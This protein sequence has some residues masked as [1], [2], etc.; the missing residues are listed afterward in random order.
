MTAAS[1]SAS[2]NSFRP[3]VGMK[4]PSKKSLSPSTSMKF[5]ETDITNSGRSRCLSE[6]TVIKTVAGDGGNAR[7]EVGRLATSTLLGRPGSVVVDAS[8]NLYIADS[9]NSRILMVTKSTGIVTAVAGNGTFDYSG[10]GG[11]ATAAQLGNPTGV[12]VDAS[13]NLYFADTSSNRIR[14]VTK[15]TGIINTVAGNGSSDGYSGDGGLATSATVPYPTGVAVDAS[16]NIYITVK[17]A[18]ILMVTKSTGII[19]TVAG[20]GTAG[21]EGDGGLA[22]SATMRYPTGITVDA[23]GNIYFADSDN[24]CIRMVTKS[25]GIITTVAGVRTSAIYEYFSGDGGP[26]TSAT[27]RS[28][29][30]VAVDASGN[31]Y[32]SDSGNNRI[33]MVTKSTGIITTVAGKGTAGYGGDGRLATSAKLYSPDGITVD[34]SGNIYFADSDNNR[35]RMVTKSTGVISVAAGDG[36]VGYAGNAVQATSARLYSPR[37]VT[38]DASGNIYITDWYSN[39]I[40]MMEKTTG[41]IT[42]VAGNTSFYGVNGV[43]GY[44][45]DG[46]PAT[47]ATLYHPRD[48]AVDASGNIYIADSDNHRVRMVMKSTGVISTVAGTGSAG[49]SGDGSLATSCK[50]SAPRGVALDASGNIYIAEVAKSRILMVTKST[51]IITTVAG[52]GTVGYSGDGGLATSATVSNPTGMTFDASGNLYFADRNRV[53]MVTKSTGIITTVAGTGTA[54]YSGDGGLATSARINLALS[55]AVDALGN[56]Y[57]ADAYNN[58]IRMVTKSTGI[59]TTVAGTGTAGYSGDG[60][61]ATLGMMDRPFGI[62]IDTAGTIYVSDTFNDRLRVLTLGVASASPPTPSPS[63][64]PSVSPTLSNPTLAFSTSASSG[65]APVENILAVNTATYYATLV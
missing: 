63:P 5:G 64:S 32:I 60:G 13:G 43:G 21:Y 34:A 48:V 10:D 22:T 19:T 23:S 50:L 47:L 7:A 15:S 1:E 49:Y 44:G 61:Q 31:I 41:I 9:S 4:L 57:I 28:P 58:R 45:G 42:I 11:V 37:G 52:T 38:S 20:K 53:R 40:R 46:G 33:R 55:V 27:M 14:M 39:T 35:I 3:L 62:T 17:T 16:G 8:G 65:E 12:A 54:G 29:R 30:D 25:T 59:I 26:A 51:G 18:R 56:L 36:T 2:M 6:V 24:N